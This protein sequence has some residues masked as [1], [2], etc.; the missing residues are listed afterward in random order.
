MNIQGTF[1]PK[2]NLTNNPYNYDLNKPAI[3]ALLKYQATSD[4]PLK[5]CLLV[6]TEAGKQVQYQINDLADFRILEKNSKLRCANVGLRSATFGLDAHRLGPQ[7]SIKAFNDLVKNLKMKETGDSP[8]VWKAALTQ[9]FQ[10]KAV[11]SPDL[12]AMLAAF[13]KSFNG[14]YHDGTP[15]VHFPPCVEILNHGERVTFH[16]GLPRGQAGQ[17][18]KIPTGRIE[19][20]MPKTFQT[21]QTCTGLRGLIHECANAIKGMEWSNTGLQGGNPQTSRSASGDIKPANEAGRA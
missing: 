4:V 7:P 11:R 13:S 10:N 12:C 8:V 2:I 16:R 15:A 5:R 17:V 18:L 3:E 14:L 21:M 9:I 6:T 20:W 19:V 1:D